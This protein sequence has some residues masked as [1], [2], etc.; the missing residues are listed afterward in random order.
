MG[1]K[2]NKENYEIVKGNGDLEISPVYSH[3]KINKNSKAP[4]Q[5]NIIIPSEKK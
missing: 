2:T 3:V 1:N 4:S 5:K